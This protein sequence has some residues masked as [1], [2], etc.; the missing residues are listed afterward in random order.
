MT[1]SGPFHTEIAVDWRLGDG[2]TA[3][4]G[5]DHAGAASGSVTFAPRV[6]A[7][8]IRIATTDDAADEPEETVEVALSLPDPDPGLAVLGAAAAAGRILDNDGLSQVTVAAA[9]AAVAEGADAVF[10]LA[11]ANGGCV[12]RA[13]GAGG[14]DGCRRGACRRAAGKRDLRGRRGH[15][16]AEPRHRR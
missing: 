16:H 5:D 4:A 2:G 3:T 9:A 14:G 15:G 13:D 7:Q 8:T 1:L 11:R 10:T 12:G 6:T